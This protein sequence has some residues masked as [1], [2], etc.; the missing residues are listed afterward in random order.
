MPAVA[1]WELVLSRA[2]GGVASDA[3]RQLW[4]GLANSRCRPAGTLHWW[5]RVRR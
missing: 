4:S 3:E 5:R 1:A 2:P